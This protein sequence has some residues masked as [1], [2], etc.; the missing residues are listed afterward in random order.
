MTVY[1]IA[2]II[3]E[4]RNRFI[5]FGGLLLCAVLLWIYLL[6]FSQPRLDAL[7][8]SWNEKRSQLQGSSRVD[9]SKLYAENGKRLADIVASAP[10]QTEFPGVLWQMT[11]YAAK[12]RL[13]VVNMS[14][15]PVKSRINGLICYSLHCSIRGSY[16]A[17]KNYLTDILSI[18]CLPII[19]S[20]SIT[21]PE[22]GKGALTA[23]DGQEQVLLDTELLIHLR[24]EV[25]Q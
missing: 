14:Y 15:K 22:S 16:P 25:Q 11:D 10:V 21:K 5:V 9:R 17:I 20:V 2:A 3:R 18:D 8:N 23:P 6:I 24:P 1:L 13:T 4:N 7:F 19:E 12:N